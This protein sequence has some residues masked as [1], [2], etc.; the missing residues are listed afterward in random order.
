MKSNLDNWPFFPAYI[1][2]FLIMIRFLP[3]MKFYG[4]WNESTFEILCGRIIRKR[5]RLCLL[6]MIC[7]H[8]RHITNASLIRRGSNQGLY[9]GSGLS[10]LS[11]KFYHRGVKKL[12]RGNYHFKGCCHLVKF[13]RVSS[14]RWNKGH[15]EQEAMSRKQ[16]RSKWG[17]NL[18]IIPSRLLKLLISLKT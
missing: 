11:T 7:L 6:G 13:K 10:S 5:T 1:E 14:Y 18:M 8:D 15:H 17:L 2:L 3:S 4:A 16:C 9:P 12:Q